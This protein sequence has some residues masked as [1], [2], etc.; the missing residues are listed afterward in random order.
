MPSSALPPELVSLIHH[1]ELN[2]TGWWDK[3]V[4]RLIVF[5]IWLEGGQSTPE[6]IQ[7]VF[8]KDFGVDCEAVRIQEQIDGLSS[9]GVIVSLPDDQCKISEQSLKE[10]EQKIAEGQ[11]LENRVKTRFRKIFGTLCPTLHLENTWDVFHSG[12]L[13][14]LVK[15]MGARTYEIVSGSG[16][17]VFATASFNE[18]LHG[19]PQELHQSIRE[20]VIRYL[21][22][23]N[24]DIRSYVLR[25]LNAYFFVEAASLS[26]ETL[27]ALTT[28]AK[29]K[30]LFR[31]FFD[32]NV[33]FS[34]LGIHESPSNEAVRALIDLVQRVS[35]IV[36]VK[37]YVLPHTIDETRRALATHLE[38]LKNWKLT[39]NLAKAALESA[40]TGV[41]RR[42]AQEVA[43]SGQPLTPD[44]YFGPF[45][46]DL[47]TLL[48]AAGVEIYNRKTEDYNMRQDVLDD[49]LE[50]SDHEKETHGEFAKKYEQLEHDMVLWHYVRDLRPRAVESPLGAQYWVVT[51]DYR[52]LRFDTRKGRKEPMSVP[53]CLLPTALIQMLQFWVPRT[54]QL[55]AAILGTLRLPFLFQ[56]FDPEAERVTTSILRSLSRFDQAGDLSVETAHRVFVNKHLRRQIASEPKEERQIELVREALVAFDKQRT[57]ELK[58]A[59]KRAKLSET[60]VDEAIRTTRD[61]EKR[62]EGKAKEAATLKSDLHTERRAKQSLESRLAA[63]E[64]DVNARKADEDRRHDI[65]AYQRWVAISLMI[66]LAA[67]AGFSLLLLGVLGWPFWTTSSVAES[68][69]LIPWIWL[70]DRRGRTC[71]AVSSSRAFAIFHKLRIGLFALL[72]LAAI[73][74]YQTFASDAAKHVWSLVKH[75]L[76]V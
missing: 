48:R 57:A 38:P 67:A 26:Q 55:E 53:I 59:E 63:I 6:A 17:N 75:S 40:L 58:S 4:Q 43:S 24:P 70:C 33:V 56:E 65:G 11:D 49:I 45:V 64:A 35:D 15:E 19:Y 16:P 74:I 14:P 34:A 37:L 76:R 39:P 73:G 44:E 71:K 28:M 10:Y 36:D 31:V 27:N 12:L 66:T 5:I 1:V 25:H 60:K 50:E 61:M 9:V 72:A 47:M 46:T 42:Y 22:P 2:T 69:L 68:L 8:K 62:L 51:V 52:L 32:T 18:F 3:A 7:Q 13:M 41:A 54:E 21:D 30:P 29:R 23:S 20:A